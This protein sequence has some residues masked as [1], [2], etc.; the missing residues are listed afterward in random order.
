MSFRRSI[1]QPIVNVAARMYIESHSIRLIPRKRGPARICAA[2]FSRKSSAQ[3]ACKK[4]FYDPPPTE[5]R[6]QFHGSVIHSAELSITTAITETRDGRRALAMQGNNA[7]VNP[8]ECINEVRI[9]YSTA[10]ILKIRTAGK[11]SRKRANGK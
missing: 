10:K 2:C 5:L 6:A 11:R 3:K 9:L 1:W 8:Y 7:V 4:I